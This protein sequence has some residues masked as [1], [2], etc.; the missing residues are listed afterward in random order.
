MAH[1]SPSVRRYD[2]D[3]IEQTK[4]T[5]NVRRRTEFSMLV[6]LVGLV[7]TAVNQSQ[8]VIPEIQYS[9]LLNISKVSWWEEHFVDFL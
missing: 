1:L 2:R 7:I 9:H 8:D 6:G 5:S 4:K 3:P